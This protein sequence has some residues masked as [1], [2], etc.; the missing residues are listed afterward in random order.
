MADARP[1]AG[2]P[3]R[4]PLLAD[5]SLVLTATEGVWEIVESWLPHLPQ[6]D[7]GAMPAAAVIQVETG[8]PP[9]PPDEAPT[10]ELYGVRAWVSASSAVLADG[11]GRIG[12]WV[13]LAA[14][15]ATVRVN[16][17]PAERD[18]FAAF[19]ISA[20][21]LLTRLGRALVHAAAVVP[22]GGGA[23]LLPASSFAGKTTTCV[24]LARDGWSW[25]AD[26][27]V[28][29]GGGACATAEGWPRF[30]YLDR[31]YGTGASDGVRARIDPHGVAPGTWLRAAPVAGLLFPRVDADRPTA[32]SR[33]AAA[34]AFARLLRQSPWILADAAAAPAVLPLLQRVAGL[35]AWE[36]RLGGDTFSSGKRLQMVLATAVSASGNE[37]CGV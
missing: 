8:V 34:D 4:F 12:A 6:A 2:A 16:G 24:T 28:V 29:L 14:R 3:R 19:T 30:F 32:V 23:W 5:G 11:A 25:L 35:P 22:P 7:A 27:H 9:T 13:D 15:H 18:V 31:G 26:D 37:G 33:L 36:L 17:D 1:V 10:M 21:M 20:G